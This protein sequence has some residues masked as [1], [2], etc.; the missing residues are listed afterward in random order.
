[1]STASPVSPADAM[2]R[3]LESRRPGY[4]L[5]GAFFSDPGHFA[6]EME[7]IFRKDW[8]FAGHTCEISKPGQ[9]FTL[10]VGAHPIVVMR[11]GDGGLR[12]F[13]NVCRHRGH[14][15]CAADKGQS[16][17]RIVC[18]Y[19]QWAYEF[20]GSLARAREMQLDVDVRSLGLKPV[21]VRAVAGYVFISLAAEPE[22]FEPFGRLVAA[23]VTPFDIEGA[24]V[25][26]ESRI[27]EKGNWKIV[28]ENNRE[29][30]HCRG[31]HPELTRTFPETPSHS[32]AGDPALQAEIDA[33]IAK[34]EV[35]GFPG[36]FVM[37]D[38]FQ[39]RLM[40]LPLEGA[41]RSMTMSGQPAVAK[42]LGRAPADDNIGDV[43]C[44]HYPTTWNHFTADH[45]LSFRVLPIS[46]GETEV[47]TRWLVP[48]DAIEGRDYDL[49][50]LTE[51]WI[52]TN[53]QDMR[54]VEETQRGATSPAYEPGPFSEVQEDGCIKFVDW[55]TSTMM[56]RLGG[57]P[58]LKMAAE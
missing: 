21:H 13:H 38:D 24:K 35:L 19:H 22:D 28:W 6:L 10:Q 11:D 31:S 1:M 7:H 18:P 42:R 53:D 39:H 47:V 23:Y 46:P 57:G 15:V 30:Y 25:A 2:R 41:A 9:W 54:L 16:A 44:Y 58:A 43:L 37:A 27:I 3:D 26:H 12:A 51:V 55:Y 4:G 32:G 56:R 5:P 36:K 49:K 17:R 48:G 40:R 34:C 45:A 50:T 33:M 14:R 52:A 20:D 29:C 8:L